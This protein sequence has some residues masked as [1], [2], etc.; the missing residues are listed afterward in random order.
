[1]KQ[2][3]IVFGYT[4]RDAVRKKAFIISSVIMV[5]LVL[6]L[7]SI[8]NFITLFS[9]DN[10]NSD[11]TINSGNNSSSA[12]NTDKTCYYIDENNLISGTEQ[13]LSSVFPDV[14]FV[15]ADNDMI[16]GY[17]KEIED[18]ADI[19]M[20]IVTEQ[21]RLPFITVVSKDFMS[22]IPVDTV[23]GLLSK[24]YISNTLA[25]QGI[26]SD[27]IAF[28]QMQL[29]YASDM[30]G[31]MNMSGYVLGIVLTMLIFFAIYYYGYGVSMSIA[32][33]KTSRVMETLIVSA[34]PSRILL[35][36][37]MAMGVLGLCQFSG[38]IIF[39]AAC[40]RLLIP[41]NFTLMGVPLS[42]SAFSAGSAVLIIV[43]FILGYSLYAVMNA[44]CGAS[45]SKIEDL[46]SAMMPVMMTAML[47]FYIGYFT[48]VTG[49]GNGLFQ[50]IAM[51]IPF[52]S[53]F[54]VPFKLLN[55]DISTLDLVIS[56]TALIIA[57]IVITYV[58]IRIYS[59]S[60]LHY[61]KKLKFKEAYKTK[62]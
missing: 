62:L 9:N 2:I 50:K 8:P 30:V 61:G 23:A 33:E 45:V 7:F 13:V 40:Y 46:N 5:L 25:L 15:T 14:N 3:M 39:T 6:V 59:A 47:S 32:S 12:A 53:P 16:D 26:D 10:N 57:I 21:D 24:T 27:T 56:I 18:N 38:I 49:A 22:G 34:K 60:V 37:C 1:M 48:A 28:A 35:G 43:Y 4:F 11:N 29:P 36:K 52:C 19:S 55:S 42:L 54:I 58:S 17:K 31:N 41:D 44:V 20:I 51:Y